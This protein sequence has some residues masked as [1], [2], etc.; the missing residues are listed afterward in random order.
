MFQNFVSCTIMMLGCVVCAS[1]FSSSAQLLMPLMILSVLF[2]FVVTCYCLVGVSCVYKSCV[3]IVSQFGT[4][5]PALIFTYTGIAPTCE[6]VTLF[7]L[8][9]QTLYVSAI[10]LTLTYKQINQSRLVNNFCYA[11]QICHAWYHFY[12]CYCIQERSSSLIGH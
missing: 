2:R 7:R 8:I 5:T 6:K 3:G 4:Y 12:C 10:S 9:R 11:T 1:C